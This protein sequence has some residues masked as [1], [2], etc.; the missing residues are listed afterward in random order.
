[1]LGGYMSHNSSKWWGR[2]MKAVGLA[3]DKTTF[4]SFRHKFIDLMRDAKVQSSVE[5]AIAGHEEGTVHSNYGSKPPFKLMKE[6]LDKV[7]FDLPFDS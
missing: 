1:M 2:Y 6:E 3:S 5:Y 4:H 7:V